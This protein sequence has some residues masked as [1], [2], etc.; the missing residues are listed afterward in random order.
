MCPERRCFQNHKV[1]IKARIDCI[2]QLRK[3]SYP[4]LDSF[5]ANTLG[6]ILAWC[7]ERNTL[8]HALVTLNNYDGMDAKF[9]ALARK[10]KLLVEKLYDETT[11]F[12]N[13]YYE[14][15]EMPE[16]PERVI[17]TCRLLKTR[18]RRKSKNG[19]SKCNH[20]GRHRQ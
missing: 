9:L 15:A 12:R 5:D 16:F 18:S 14:L 13:G 7:N 10:G 4:H 6:Q 19:K 8:V 20:Y 11:T 17:I 1:G 2:K 3:Q